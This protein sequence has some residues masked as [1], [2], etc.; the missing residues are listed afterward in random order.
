MR[1][2]RLVDK[3]GHEFSDENICNLSLI[4]PP[5]HEAVDHTAKHTTHLAK[6][7]EKTH[8][9]VSDNKHHYCSHILQY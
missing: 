5:Q 2:V 9:P 8:L 1:K 3:V 4:G 6:I 7:T